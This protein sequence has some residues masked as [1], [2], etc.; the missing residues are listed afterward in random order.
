MSK[1]PNIVSW[2]KRAKEEFI[3]YDDVNQKGVNMLKDYFKNN[4]AKK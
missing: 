3:D 4:L 2:M 1:Y